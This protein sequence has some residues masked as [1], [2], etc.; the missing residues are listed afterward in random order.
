[1]T[2]VVATKIMAHRGK[3]RLWL[4]G[5]RLE[6][7]G[8][9]MGQPYRVAMKKGALLLIAD[10]AGD[11]RV[12]G[13]KETRLPIIDLK[14]EELAKFFQ[15]G[16]KLIAIMRKGRIIV[17]RMVQAIKN[18][19][20]VNRL[21]SKIAL[22][23]KLDVGCLFHGGGVMARS[24]H[25]GLKAGG[26][27]SRLAVAVE[28]EEKYIE[29][30]LRAN[31]DLFDSESLIINGPIQDFA[32]GKV[33]QLDLLHAGIPCT[34]AS[35][36]GRARCKTKFAESHD[37]AGTLFFNLMQ[38]IQAANPAIV[39]L[40]CVKQFLNTASMEIVR[41]LLKTWGYT[42]SESVLKGADFGALENRERMV[43]VAYSSEL[44]ADHG[45]FKFERLPVFHTKPENLGAVLEPIADNDDAWR[46]HGYLIEKEK[47]DLAENKSFKRQL[48][49]A[50]SPTIGTLTRGLAKRRSTD[51]MIVNERNGLTRLVSVIEHAR[52]KQIPEEWVASLEVSVTVAH[53]IMGQG[54]IY[55]KF[56]SVAAGVCGWLKAGMADRD[57]ILCELAA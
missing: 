1:M 12:S 7:S 44:E 26:V 35:V 11:M 4:Q 16:E 8:F 5:N 53:E 56:F 29:A 30:S 51:P 40:E 6:R 42:L 37:A 34:A 18:K 31:S 15:I 24:V 48:F 3:N 45:A 17:K 25:D 50:D 52:C 54:V 13:R 32:I 49:T 43:V 55:S 10:A 2:V 57:N 46:E 9:S 41:G 22:K 36:S 14:A 19:S 28:L 27:D 23:Q 47:R 33:P 20:R 39:I 21:L 38:W